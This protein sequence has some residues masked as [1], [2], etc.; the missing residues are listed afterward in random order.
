MAKKI[1]VLFFHPRYENSIVNQSLVEAIR[2]LPG[3]TLHDLYEVYPDFDID[4]QQE[5]ELLLQHDI[6]VWQHPFYWYSCPPLMKQWIDLVLE[7]GW[8]YGRNGT[9]LT[10]KTIFNCISAGGSKEV[11]RE[12]GRNRFS[13]GEFLR[14]FE[15]TAFLCHMEYWPPFVVHQANVTTS[16]MCQSYAQAYRNL[17]ADLVEGN[18]D[19]AEISQREYLNIHQYSK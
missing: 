14:P 10:G 1:L 12:G 8:A 11:Y 9:Q 7:Y 15:Q 4:I 6:I 13:I 17:L 16:T 19:A 5:K 3:V 2:D 18:Y